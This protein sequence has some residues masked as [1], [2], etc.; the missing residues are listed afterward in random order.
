[1]LADPSLLRTQCYIDG[2]W[3]DADDGQTIGIINP[4]TQRL[5]GTVAKAGRAEPRRAIHAAE[6]AGASWRESHPGAGDGLR[7]CAWALMGTFRDARR[8]AGSS[9][10]L[11]PPSRREAGGSGR[12]S[13]N[14]LSEGAGGAVR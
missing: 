14:P 4:A 12:T 9:N 1:M 11:E 6:R 10:M 5:L 7:D 2:T 13:W 8:E 3:V